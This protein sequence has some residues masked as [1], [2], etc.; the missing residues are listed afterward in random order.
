MLKAKTVMPNKFWILE[1]YR[2]T[3]KGTVSVQNEHVKV[4]V[5][6]VEKTYDSLDSACWDLSI[7]L[8]VEEE[9]DNH[10]SKSVHEDV[11]GYPVKFKAYNPIWDIKRKLPVFTKT[12]KSYTL[13]A[14]GYY[15]VEF[16]T[17]WTQAFC[18]KISTLEEYTFQ[19]PFKD[20]I[21]TRERLRKAQNASDLN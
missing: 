9:D 10:T 15:I 17:G 2:G 5:D 4:I 19:G 11:L 16:E 8:A 20:I 3:K 7:N 13:F 21:E 14:A 6:D 18:P 12:E 1:D